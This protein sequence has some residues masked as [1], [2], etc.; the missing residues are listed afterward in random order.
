MSNE[1][2]L[3]LHQRLVRVMASMGAVGK[4]GQATY[5]DR[6]AYHKIDDIDDKLRVALVEHGVVATIVD[7]R[8]R[9]LEHYQET[10]KYGKVKTT[11]YSECVIVVE[12][13]NAD[14]PSDK[15]QI[16]GWGQGLDNGDKATGKAISY[17]AK[18][19]Y[20]SAFHLRGQPDNEADNIPRGV[21]KSELVEAMEKEAVIVTDV[22]QSWIDAINQC[23]DIESFE[24]LNKSIRS[25]SKELQDSIAGW[26]QE[27]EVKCWTLD[28][29]RCKS[30]KELSGYAEKLR[31]RPEYLARP[32]REVYA[33][34]MKSLKQ[35]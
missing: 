32:L 1:K 34:K 28:V 21:P 17:A 11:W 16:I 9:K 15:S 10:D 20:L 8:D 2:V 31:G 3:N 19:A 5:G 35:G 13:V 6:Y 30:V 18:A 4:S 27:A 24:M 25:E 12:L 23:D 26:V 7:I 29:N 14:N 22:M 33:I